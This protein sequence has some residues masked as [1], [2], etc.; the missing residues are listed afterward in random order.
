[1]S[2]Y[3][4]IK[5]KPGKCGIQV[6]AAPD[7]KSFY[8]HN[9]QVYSGKSDGAREKMQDLWVV[10]YMVCHIYG[11]RRGVTTD[12]LFTCY[13][14]AN[15]LLTKGMTLGGTI[16]KNEPQIS[17]LFVS[18]KQ[19]QVYSSLS[20]FNNDLTLVWHVP[21]R[22]EAVIFLSSQRHDNMYMHGW[23]IS[24]KPEIIMRNNAT[25]S[26]CNVLDKLV[27][28]CT[29]VRSTRCWTLK[30]FFSFIAAACVNAFVL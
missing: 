12:N 30:L 13:E 8:A 3:M 6:W 26:G 24:H 21:A 2:F 20:P 10:K 17:A 28:E 18:G 14:Q 5:S 22:N 27:R 29:F 15:C 23:G 1:M 25:K 7:V 4:F 19:R 9:T 11:T 16:R